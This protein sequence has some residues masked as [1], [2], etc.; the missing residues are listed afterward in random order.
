MRNCVSFIKKLLNDHI[1]ARKSPRKSFVYSTELKNSSRVVSYIIP[2]VKPGDEIR[3]SRDPLWQWV[4]S[5]LFQISIYVN[6]YISYEESNKK[7]HILNYIIVN[8]RIFNKLKLCFINSIFCLFWSLNTSLKIKK[9][10]IT[11][12]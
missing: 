6:Y 7:T 12:I 5:L 1:S 11:R 8:F 9:V 2:C 10:N 4:H 3:A